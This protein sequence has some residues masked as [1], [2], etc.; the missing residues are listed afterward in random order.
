MN[1]LETA[2]RTLAGCCDGAASKDQRGF[3]KLDAPFGHK[4]ARTPEAS[5]TPRQSRAIWAM[6]RKYQGQLSSSGI[7]Y[8]AIPEPPKPDPAEK[9]PVRLITIDD[10]GYVAVYFPYD[11]LLVAAVKS[12]SGSRFDGQRKNWWTKLSRDNAPALMR[13]AV[14]EN[15]EFGDRVVNCIEAV[16]AEYAEKLGASRAREAELE[17]PGLGGV[18]MRE[19]K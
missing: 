16:V 11:A 2:V 5:W 4:L 6:L 8:D 9:K 14:N 3:N 13:F 18:R 1:S 15:F 17:I 7:D 12:I 10:K 19:R